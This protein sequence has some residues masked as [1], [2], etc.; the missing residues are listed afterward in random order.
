MAVLFSNTE[1]PYKLRVKKKE[2]V[3]LAGL[4]FGPQKPCPNL[5]MNSFIPELEELYRGVDF[6]VHYSENLLRVRAL[7]IAGTCDLLPKALFMNI[8]QYDSI[9]GCPN[10]KI[11]TLAQQRVRVYP[12]IENLEL[13]ST[14]ESLSYREYRE[15]LLIMRTGKH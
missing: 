2:N 7:T 10:C 11:R 15:K 6:E 4:W 9:Y 8:K 12:L 13:R 5:F 14:A 3:L 1:L